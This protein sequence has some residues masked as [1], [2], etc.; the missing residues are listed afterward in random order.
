MSRFEVWWRSPAGISELWT[1]T[2]VLGPSDA[3][4]A[5]VTPTMVRWING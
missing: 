5:E 2:R 1:Q 3:G 4:A